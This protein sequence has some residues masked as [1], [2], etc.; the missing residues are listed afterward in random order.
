[1]ISSLVVRAGG[2]GDGGGVPIKLRGPTSL[3]LVHCGRVK[4]RWLVWPGRKNDDETNLVD[5]ST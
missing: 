2:A 5:C 4:S 3:A 1:M